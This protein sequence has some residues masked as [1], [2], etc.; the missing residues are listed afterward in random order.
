MRPDGRVLTCNAQ[1]NSDLFGACRGAGGGNLGIHTSFT[2]QTFP[3]TQLTIFHLKWR[4]RHRQ[5]LG[6]LNEVMPTT[7]RELGCKVSL[8]AAPDGSLEVRL[9]GQLLGTPAQL[10][11][12]LAPV[13]AT[14]TP[15]SSQ[16]EVRPYWDAREFLSVEGAPGFSHERSHYVFDELSEAA[17]DTVVDF[18]LRWPGTSV[19][20]DWKFF[21]MGG[22]VSEVASGATAYVHRQATMVS[23]AEPEWSAQDSAKTIAENH[24]W[25]QRFP[26]G[27]SRATGER[28]GSGRP[29]ERVPFPAEHSDPPVAE[30]SPNE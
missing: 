8:A 17:L 14:A 22:A 19:S 7:P 10:D 5:V 21:L 28:E 16:M 26:R 11:S 2:F 24:A 3:V 4:S 20:A 27:Q 25:L 1:Q 18:M 23:S 13:L 12:L 30:S 9:L 15:D 29:K 6:T